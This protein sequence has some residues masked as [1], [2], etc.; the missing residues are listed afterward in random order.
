[1][2]PTALVASDMAVNALSV[3]MILTGVVL[4]VVTVRFWRSAGEDP[5]V[6]APLEVMGDR[7]FARAGE[8]ERLGILNSVRPEGRLCWST[9]QPSN[10]GRSGT[11]STT[12]TMPSTWWSQRTRTTPGPAPLRSRL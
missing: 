6:L 8:E 9:N 12:A 2:S 5:E 11:V 7:R 1:M 3:A 4:F 10:A